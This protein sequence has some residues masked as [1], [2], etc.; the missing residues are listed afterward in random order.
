MEAADKPLLRDLLKKVKI[1]E[2]YRLG[3]ELN[4]DIHRLDIIEC[5]ENR[6]EDKLKRVFQKW[7][8]V[9][10]KPSWRAIINALRA[11]HRNRLAT[12]LEDN[13]CT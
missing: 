5:D 7:L 8:E 11:I 3:L 2:W 13:F 1:T 10:S 6:E 9:C 12:E 4:I